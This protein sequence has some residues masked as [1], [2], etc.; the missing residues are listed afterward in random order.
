LQTGL[1]GPLPARAAFPRDRQ[2]AYTT[3]IRNVRSEIHAFFRRYVAPS[4]LAGAVRVTQRDRETYVDVDDDVPRLP[5][6]RRRPGWKASTASVLLR[7][8]QFPE[9]TAT[10]GIHF[11]DG[12]DRGRTLYLRHNP[13]GERR[14]RS[15]RGQ[16]VAAL[17]FH[18]D[19]D[20]NAPVLVTNLAIRGDSDEHTALSRAAGGWLMAYLLEVARQDGRPNEVGVEINTQPNKHDFVAIGFRPAPTPAA[21]AAPY[22][23]FRAP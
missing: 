10:R 23:A 15:Y 14:E 7:S 17:S 1:S 5:F 21:Y 2:D 11:N 3:A 12:K 13:Q 8:D 16:I 6:N 19:E 4:G 18:I 9:R 20:S 22:W